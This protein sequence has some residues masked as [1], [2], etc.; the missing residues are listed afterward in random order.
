MF[1]LAI[2]FILLATPAMAQKNGDISEWFR[3]LKMPSNIGPYSAGTSCC[4]QSDCKRRA[5]SL[6]PSGALQAWIEEIG[7]FAPVLPQTRITDPEVIARHPFF[8]AVVCYVPGTGV[9]CY[10]PPPAGG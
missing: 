3:S 6:S 7:D 10:A 2:L 8:Q 9:V 1:S 5:I 4:D